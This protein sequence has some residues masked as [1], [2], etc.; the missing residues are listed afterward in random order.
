MRLLA[1][2]RSCTPG[3]THIAPRRSGTFPNVDLSYRDAS[4]VLGMLCVVAPTCIPNEACACV[5][6]WFPMGWSVLRST[7]VAG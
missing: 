2:S 7:S 1:L 4:L 5:S 6:V 3:R